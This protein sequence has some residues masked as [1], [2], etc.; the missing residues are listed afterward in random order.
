ML[1]VIMHLY[2]SS[3]KVEQYKRP[4][5]VVGPTMVWYAV[6][7][8]GSRPGSGPCQLPDRTTPDHQQG[9]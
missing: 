2:L 5:V 1:N 3:E 9:Y 4:M 7:I 8:P 6:L